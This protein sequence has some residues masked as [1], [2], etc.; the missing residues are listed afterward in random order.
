MQVL[1]FFPFLF[2]AYLVFA[3]KKYGMSR[4]ISSGYGRLVKAEQ[5]LPFMVMVLAIIIPFTVLGVQATHGKWLQLLWLA[6]S[7]LLLL[8]A[9]F[10]V[11]KSGTLH[12]KLHVIG[13]TGGMAFH[14]AAVIFTIP[15]LLPKL[16]A[17][18]AIL[19]IA[20]QTIKKLK[21]KLDNNT[22]WIEVAYGVA[23]WL[24]LFI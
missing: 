13:A 9:V 12:E 18:V 17:G 8:V 6:G 14:L 1:H 3:I 16:I 21:L 2:A 10:P 4:S 7:A 19:F 5:L 20:T 24:A 11:T 22:Y 23:V 15:G